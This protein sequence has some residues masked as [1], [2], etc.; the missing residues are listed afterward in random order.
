[1]ASHTLHI[2]RNPN[3]FDPENSREI[4]AEIRTTAVRIH[5]LCW[6]ANDI[7]V[8]EKD[9]RKQIEARMELQTQALRYCTDL[10]AL[11]NL[12]KPLY[13][14]SGKKTKNWM[15]KVLEVQNLISGWRD[16]DRSRIR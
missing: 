4:I 1:M 5:V 9:N 8:P 11:I 16:S 2:T 14:V 15:R 10:K 7:R 3:V 12:A 13:H 6:R